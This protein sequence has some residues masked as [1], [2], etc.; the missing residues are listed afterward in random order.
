M[1]AEAF[2]GRADARAYIAACLV[3]YRARIELPIP[4]RPGLAVMLDFCDVRGLKKSV[5]TSSGRSMAVVKLRSGGI[6][7]RFDILVTATEVAHGKPAPDI[8]LRCAELMGV[9]PA[10]CVVLEDSPMGIAAA[11]T[12]G[13]R[14][15]MVPDMIEPSAEVRA[16]T[17]GVLR[18]LAEAPAFFVAQGWV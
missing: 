17:A 7:G 13:M 15:V 3:V 10:E 16:M 9:T 2:A 12:A 11:R 14:S 8:F 5:G 4:T 18:S 6:D 1:V